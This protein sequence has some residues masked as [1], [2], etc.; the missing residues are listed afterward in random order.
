MARPGYVL[1]KYARVDSGQ[2]FNGSFATSTILQR[3][4][5]CGTGFRRNPG[6]N[7][8]YSRRKIPTT[9]DFANLKYIRII[10]YGSVTCYGRTAGTRA[11]TVRIEREKRRPRENFRQPTQCC[12]TYQG[13]QFRTYFFIVCSTGISIGMQTMIV[14]L[15]RS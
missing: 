12:P 8:V 15:S 9:M 7:G 6:Y 14:I 13:K 5:L 4:G 1:L 2:Y 3:Y 11:E 10:D